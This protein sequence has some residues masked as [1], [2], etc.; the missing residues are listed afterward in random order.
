METKIKINPPPELKNKLSELTVIGQNATDQNVQNVQNAS[1]ASEGFKVLVGGV[2]APQG[3]LAAAVSAEI[4]YPDRRDL[5]LLYSEVP[6][7]AAALYT[8]NKVQAAPI[9][10]TREYLQDGRAQAVV[11]NSGIANAGTGQPGLADAR[12]TAELV[13]EA[14]KLKTEDVAVAS[15]GVIGMRLP[16]ERVAA[17]IAQAAASLSAEAGNE[18][19]QAIMTTDTRPKEI[20]IKV[21]LGGH[22]ITIAGMAKGSGMIHPNMA[23]ML[24]FLTTDAEVDPVFL[25]QALTEATRLSFNMITVDGD[26]STNDMVI[27]LANGQA[28]TP[29]ILGDGRDAVAFQQ[30]LNAVTQYLAKEIARDGEG[31]T[32][33][34]EVR[35]QGAASLS[36]AQKAGRAIAGSSLVKS[37]VYG[38][39]ANWGRILAA[40]GYS[41]AEFD[42]EQ[43]TIWL[44]EVLVAEQGTP[45]PFDEDE[46]RRVLAA[47]T[48]VITADLGAG[49]AR[50][51]AWGCDLTFDYIKINANYRS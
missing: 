16:M 35:I 24:A 9:V 23:T 38:Q 39:D 14:L 10:V 51:V 28:Q 42:P 8:Q 48:V 1:E 29:R 40:A 6:A 34:I 36:D 32:R 18:A 11:I 47:D 26:T 41:G 46:A 43:T 21:D 4:R 15:T 44:G 37:A 19:A 17:G 12:R 7:V 30:A 33:L 27:I 45:V 49:N 5:A 2:T 22:F 25:H 3:F 13:A 50:A 20:A 31:A